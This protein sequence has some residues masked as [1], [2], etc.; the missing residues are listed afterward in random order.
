[1]YEF[2]TIPNSIVLSG[3]VT[4]PL[5]VDV[6]RK[7]CRADGDT[8]TDFTG[9]ITT[10]RRQLEAHTSRTI[11]S[12][13]LTL[14]MDRFPCDAIQIRRPPVSAVS[15]VTYT[16][17]DGTSTTWTSSLWQSSLYREPPIIVPAYGETWP[18]TRDQ[19]DAVTVTCTAGFANEQ[20]PA[21]YKH[22]MLLLMGH[23]YWH[24]EATTDVRLEET[25][26][27]YQR[28]VDLL[29]WGNYR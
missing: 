6:A 29:S 23:L 13:T 14:R 11:A 1:M 10:C 25:P 12:Q 3:T 7:H 17:T 15:S 2:H 28:M 4:E 21:D 18:T 26:M 8:E 16:D 9:L 5:T 19:L 22:A 24:R 27:A 20:V